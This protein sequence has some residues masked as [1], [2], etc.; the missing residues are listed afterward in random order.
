LESLK[1]ETKREYRYI[2]PKEHPPSIIYNPDGTVKDR[3][4]YDKWYA[5]KKRRSKYTPVPYKEK[6]K[7]WDQMSEDYWRKYCKENDLNPDTW[8]KVKKRVK[9]EKAHR[10]RWY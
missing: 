7:R 1:T 8:R 4:E 2:D 9:A 10:R 6:R 3:R 5:K